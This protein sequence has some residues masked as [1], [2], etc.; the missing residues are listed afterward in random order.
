MSEF[1]EIE[2]PEISPLDLCAYQFGAAL[3]RLELWALWLANAVFSAEFFPLTPPLRPV[4]QPG[5]LGSLNE[6]ELGGTPQ[7]ID[8]S[9]P[10]SLI[11]EQER[12]FRRSAEQELGKICTALRAALPPLQFLMAHTAVSEHQEL[13]R[14]FNELGD[15]LDKLKGL[16]EELFDY[17]RKTPR[18]WDESDFQ[19][20]YFE[21]VDPI[22]GE[23]QLECETP[24]AHSLRVR[25]ALSAWASGETELR[26]PRIYNWFQA[27]YQQSNLEFPIDWYLTGRRL[28]AEELKKKL[29]SP[30]ITLP[31]PFSVPAGPSNR[32]QILLSLQHL[33]FGEVPDPQS[34]EQSHVQTRLLKLHQN[35][36]K[37]RPNFE[38][39]KQSQTDDVLS[40]CHFQLTLNITQRLLSRDGFKP[41]TIEQCDLEVVKHFLRKTRM[42]PSEVTDIGTDGSNTRF[43]STVKTAIKRANDECFGPLNLE[44]V[45]TKGQR[46][47]TEKKQ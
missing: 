13:A 20:N 31:N 27:S 14:V 9:R 10:R 7:Y 39:T 16:P 21:L 46:T 12:T 3:Q 22:D 47:L 5:L 33:G 32:Y 25:K 30:E 45:S 41:V 19:E 43:S 37:K 35:L 15:M 28:A 26:T 29:T 18:L 40:G 42:I 4:P 24:Q 38:T 34:G 8:F 2:Q 1:L 23:E 44:I 11:T 36:I 6:L 17:P